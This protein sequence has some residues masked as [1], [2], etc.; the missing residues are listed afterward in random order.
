[1]CAAHQKVPG[2]RHWCAERT[3]RSHFI[4]STLFPPH[5]FVVFVCFVVKTF[6]IFITYFPFPFSPGI[7]R[8]TKR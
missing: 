8:Q 6:P 4:S 5:S 1:M 3:L 2:E 7:G